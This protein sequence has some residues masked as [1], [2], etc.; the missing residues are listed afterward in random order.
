[1]Y[2]HAHLLSV[3][4]GSSIDTPASLVRHTY[5]YKYDAYSHTCTHALIHVHLLSHM[6]T[7][8]H[9]CTCTCTRT[10][11]VSHSS[12]Q[13]TLSPH[14]RDISV[15]KIY[16]EISCFIHVHTYTPLKCHIRLFNRY[17]SF[18]SEADPFLQGIQSLLVSG[19]GLL[20]FVCAP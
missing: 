5:L 2:V 9:T 16:Y 13:Q 20:F 12:L 19:A 4:L 11:S 17:P 15:H 18:I 3:T 7:N 8:S 6:Y 10:S 14:Q 1:M